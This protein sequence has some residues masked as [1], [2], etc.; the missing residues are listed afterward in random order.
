MNKHGRPQ[1]AF[2]FPY[3]IIDKACPVGL[4]DGLLSQNNPCVALVIY[5]TALDHFIELYL[6]A[7][8]IRVNTEGKINEYHGKNNHANVYVQWFL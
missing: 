8:D 4:S 7:A 1:R 6:I 5:D 2:A 3:V